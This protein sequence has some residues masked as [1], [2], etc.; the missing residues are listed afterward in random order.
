MF[1]NI[2]TFSNFYQHF[3]EHSHT[4]NRLLHNLTNSE[5]L[6][7]WGKILIYHLKGKTASVFIQEEINFT[8]FYNQEVV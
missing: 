4:I 7:V 3:I 6:Y 2:D 5:I 1:L 8:S